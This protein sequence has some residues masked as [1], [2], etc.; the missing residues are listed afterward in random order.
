MRQVYLRKKTLN[1]VISELRNTISEQR[2]NSNLQI[3]PQQGSDYFASVSAKNK[4]YAE[5]VELK[6]LL[7]KYSCVPYNMV[8]L[9]LYVLRNK[10]I[11]MKKLQVS[12]PVLIFATK[13]AIG[14]MGRETDFGQNSEFTD[15][16]AIF[17]RQNGLGGLADLGQDIYNFV[18]GTNSV[19]SLGPAQFTKETWK[20]YGFQDTIGDFDRSFNTVSQGIATVF[21]L[22]YD[23]REALSN[24]SGTGPS[25]NPI[26]VKQGKIT[27]IQGTGNN[28]W[29]LS[30]VAHNRGKAILGSYCQTNNPDFACRCNKNTCQPY[31][32]SRK[33][34][35]LNVFTDKKIPN[36]F[37]NL[38]S[39][40]GPK[41]IGYLEE[42]V[43]SIQGYNCF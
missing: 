34:F 33:D 30:I 2:D 23:Y 25:E 31:P 1:K 41:S 17:L 14:I 7:I 18:K 26:A 40:N 10:E 12:E 20:D 35:V 36:Y 13:L 42:V 24:G 29:D 37:P 8:A 19:Q 39:G 11:L 3:R 6:K 27:N 28:T 38:G 22:I 5:T 15:D 16:A 43:K 21:R 4:K 9:V 32:K